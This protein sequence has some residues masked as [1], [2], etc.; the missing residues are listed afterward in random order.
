MTKYEHQTTEGSII[1]NSNEVHTIKPPSD[2]S[3][4]IDETYRRRR[5]VPDRQVGPL[6][7]A[8]QYR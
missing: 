3:H 5:K 2:D 8:R 1:L 6:I 7:K 4:P